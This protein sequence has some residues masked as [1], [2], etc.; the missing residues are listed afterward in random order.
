MGNFRLMSTLYKIC[1]AI[2]FLSC[3]QLWK[4]CAYI[5]M[6]ECTHIETLPCNTSGMSKHSHI[7]LAGCQSTTTWHYPTVLAC[8]ICRRAGSLQMVNV[9]TNED[10]GPWKGPVVCNQMLERL[11]SSRLLYV[12][13][14]V[15]WSRGECWALEIFAGR[16]N[17]CWFG[18]RCA[19]VWPLT[20]RRSLDM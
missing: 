1:L 11:D 17:S 9:P 4:S 5:Y 3:I 15:R 18:A 12:G 8:W 14:L 16:Q 7:A 19:V 20:G 13:L 10:C 2:K 6:W